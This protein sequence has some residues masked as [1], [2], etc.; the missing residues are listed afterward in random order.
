[1][2]GAP[3][4]ACALAGLA[5]LGLGGTLSGAA[6]LAAAAGSWWRP[7]AAPRS[8]VPFHV[9]VI[10]VAAAI[11]LASGTLDA[12]GFLVAWLMVHRWWVLD[13]G[14][15]ARVVVLLAALMVLLSCVASYTVAL[16]VPLLVFVACTPVALVRSYGA[17]DRR[18]DLGVGLACFLL[19]GI[20]YTVVPRI[21][22]GVGA[23]LGNAVHQRAFPRGLELGDEFADPM[24]EVP[25]LRLR[26]VD[27]AGAPRA[28]PYYV[29]GRA[30]DTFDGRRW[31]ASGTP[32]PLAGGRGHDLTVEYSVEPQFGDA[33]YLVPE[34]TR[35]QGLATAA[36]APW[37]YSF[38]LRGK[39]IEY[40]GYSRD[41]VIGEIVDA[42]EAWTRLP[43]VTPEV[44]ALAL[45][46]A[47]AESP[48]LAIVGAA[49]R[50]FAEGYVY[51]ESPPPPAGDPLT[52]FLADS[53][54]GH[55]EYYASALA[56]LLRLRGVPARLATGFYVADPPDFDGW[57]TVR[58]GHAHA[59][60]EV[61]TAR[62]WATL[63]ATPT[64]QLPAPEL[65][66]LDRLAEALR[67]GWDA[68]VL[69]YDLD[70]QVDGLAKLG[71]TF[72]DTRKGDTHGNRL[73]QG[74][75]GFGVL[76]G[77]MALLG[78]AARLVILAVSRARPARARGDALADAMREARLRARR[79][80]WDVP[81]SLPPAEAGAWLLARAGE[82]SRP[83]VELAAL[84][85]RVRYA[86]EA[87]A[88]AD[89]KARDLARALAKL[90]RP[91]GV[92]LSPEP[93]H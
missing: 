82:P 44:V 13:S 65:A 47:P 68:L 29:R 59:W 25:V 11:G 31:S 17:A 9:A 32:D 74:M 16:S 27:R 21:Q 12:F 4:R 86:G 26:A 56:V 38:P 70:T 18:L 1:M 89:A 83:L 78:T 50:H 33:L 84:Y 63:D 24:A 2:K 48:R 8:W 69:D 80:G 71:A 75:A 7:R 55:C 88:G 41:V 87:V 53:K 79:R 34:P 6:A 51:T 14:D 39:R 73:R 90:P 3:L 19:A 62:G 42:G 46:L 57:T 64:G 72:V 91:A 58:R 60:V 22:A 15:D 45:G 5:A 40:S 10:A 66:T 81:D 36:R 37:G 77:S 20:F 30:L 92:A 28:G 52:W 85:Y 35:V 76:V 49:M 67:R 23:G 93:G 54:S 61:P 43:P